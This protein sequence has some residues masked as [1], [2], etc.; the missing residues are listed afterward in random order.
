LELNTWQNISF[1][2]YIMLEKGANPA[3]VAGKITDISE[4]HLADLKPNYVLQPLLKIH[5]DPPLKFDNVAH[6]S[7][8]SVTLFSIVALSILLIAC[9]NFIN[10]STAR[11]SRR[12][13]EVGLRKVIGAR[14]PVLVR[15]FWGEALFMT[16]IAA[17]LALLGVV[18]ILPFFNSITGKEFV[19]RLIIEQKFLLPFLGIT[20][21][22]GLAS[23]FYPAFLLSSFQPAKIFRG[24]SRMCAKGS[25]LRKVLVVFQFVLT[26]ADRRYSHSR[27]RDGEAGGFPAE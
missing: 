17:C 20:I 23:G 19:L 7:R 18:L 13:L 11:S 2:S 5:L 1:Y 12:A 8:Q 27:S 4:K 25:Q 10:L 24:R 22:T 14:R 21:F 6:G 26:V 9:F 16:F 3:V 15:Q